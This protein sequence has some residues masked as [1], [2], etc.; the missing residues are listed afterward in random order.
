[1]PLSVLNSMDADH[2]VLLQEMEGIISDTLKNIKGRKKAVP[3]DVIAESQVAEQT[4]VGIENIRKLDVVQSVYACPDC[5]GP[6]WEPQNDIIKRYRCHI[7][8][9]YT[10][11]GLV[12]K[13]A[14]TAGQRF[15]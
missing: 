3:K 8:H 7:G 4:A 13:Q 14:E 11:R 9:G 15:G 6:L 10:E 1:M 2:V 12:L 5:G